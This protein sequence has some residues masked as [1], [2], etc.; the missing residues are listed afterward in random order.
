M[1]LEPFSI[2][3]HLFLY[4]T[5]L[6]CQQALLILALIHF[7]PIFLSTSSSLVYFHYCHC[8][9]PLSLFQTATDTITV[10]YQPGHCV[11][12]WLKPFS[13]FP[14]CYQL[15]LDPI[16]STSP[17]RLPLKHSLYP[18]HL[19]ALN[20]LPLKA[21]L[22]HLSLKVKRYR[23]EFLPSFQNARKTFPM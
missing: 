1:K 19:L 12:F 18:T 20:S 9:K 5:C 11:L 17:G 15:V 3:C 4:S 6:I 7:L 14:L 22:H 8:H 10:K 23:H 21:G 16:Q 13:G 2:L